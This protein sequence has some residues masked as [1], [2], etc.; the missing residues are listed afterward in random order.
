MGPIVVGGAYL[1]ER[2]PPLCH[3]VHTSLVRRMIPRPPWYMRTVP[4]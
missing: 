4:R 2:Q 3:P 1:G